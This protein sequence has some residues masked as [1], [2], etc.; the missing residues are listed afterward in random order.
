MLFRLKKENIIYRSIF[1][2]L[3]LC[4]IMF[5]CTPTSKSSD[6]IKYTSTG[7]IIN[8]KIICPSDVTDV[9]VPLTSLNPSPKKGVPK[10]S[11][12]GLKL[13]IKKEK[14]SSI[15]DLLSKLPIHYKTNFS[16]VEKTKGEGE[17]SLKFP[18]IVLFGSDGRFLINISTK[19]DDPKYELL[20]CAELNL[21]TGK[22]DFSQFDF[23]ENQPKF[24][25]EPTS[26]IR[27]HG[28]QARPIWG[29]N[30]DW[31]GVFGDNEAAGPNGEALSYKHVLVMNKIK[32]TPSYSNRF[33][34]LVWS[35]Q[36]LTSGG[37]R[38]I[39]NN[40]FGAEL[41]VSNLAMGSA[42]ARGVFLRL[43]NTYP[44]Q[45][46][47]LREELLL[48]G[49]ERIFGGVLSSKE[50]SNLK[51]AD[52]KRFNLSTVNIDVLMNHLG[53]D[54][55]VA[56]SLS[57][58]AQEEKPKKNWSLG[59]GDLYDLVLLQILDDLQK[60]DKFLAQILSSVENS[61]GIFKCKNLGK[62]IKEVIAYKMLHLFHLQGSARYKV[63][64][65]FYPQD[66]ENIKDK[67]FEPIKQPLIAYLKSK[68]TM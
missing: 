11:M 23:K 50:I 14:I 4:T 33:N 51:S 31:P 65:V 22:W 45:Y 25:K 24:H 59:A 27:C 55:N 66:V 56:F 2:V 62:N 17:S 57:T 54:T 49:C 1:R 18:R 26:C 58:L 8:D 34:F 38:R 68:T 15:T 28:L 16:L 60:D 5:N 21:T 64:K 63:N 19:P 13:F 36:K 42:T 46:L 20:D 40:A 52:L 9:I 32:K 30:M 48:L 39:A 41:L 29:T 3:L 61:P 12:D 67:V 47:K 6:V 35:D 37:I 43:K 44:S 53:V 7:G 10:M